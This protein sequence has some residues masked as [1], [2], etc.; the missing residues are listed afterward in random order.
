VAIASPLKDL[1]LHKSR[2]S[3]GE[4]IATSVIVS[5]GYEDDMELDN[6]VVIFYT[7]HGGWKKILINRKT[8]K[9]KG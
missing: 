2:S 5:G 3:N 6:G 9:M 1:F 7:G 8:D 4:P